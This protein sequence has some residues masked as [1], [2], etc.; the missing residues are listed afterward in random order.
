MGLSSFAPLASHRSAAA[1]APVEKTYAP[2]EVDGAR[3]FYE[4]SIPV[5]VLTGSPSELGR[6]QAALVADVSGPIMAFAKKFA[7]EFHIEFLWPVVR[8][9][10]KLLMHNAPQ[11]YQDELAELAEAGRLDAADLAVFNTLLELRR[12]GCSAIVV[13]GEHATTGAPLFGR[14]FDFPTLGVLHKYSLLLIVRPTGK[15]AF[16]SIA[17]PGAVG[18]VSGMNDAGLSVGTLDVYETGDGS[19]MFDPTGAPLAMTFRRILEECTTVEQAV[20]LLK[21]VKRTTCMNLMVCD[22]HGGAVLEITPKQVARRDA[23]SSEH[24][25]AC[26]NHFRLK[27]LAVDTECWRYPLLMEAAQGPKLDVAAVQ[28][29]LD[30]ANQGADTLQTMVFEPRELRLHV[31]FGAGPTSALP[32]EKIDLKSLFEWSVKP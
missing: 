19:S 6:Q 14:N 20:E 13:D 4:G 24:V 23:E 28:R 5:A 30:A 16:A 29:R 32:L 15:H 25:V 26:T 22:V 27:G 17:F 7:A 2:R 3:L 10:G 11:A 9:A 21:S 18:V 31:A 12:M 8:Q 1:K